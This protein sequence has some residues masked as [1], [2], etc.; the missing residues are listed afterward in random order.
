M[1]SDELF[2]REN[3]CDEL[4]MEMGMPGVYLLLTKI[5]SLNKLVSNVSL[6][7]YGVRS[8]DFLVVQCLS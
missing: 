3:L 4:E 6:W 1:E 7:C 5:Q 8:A 2:D